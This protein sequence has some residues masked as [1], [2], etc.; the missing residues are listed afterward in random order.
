LA[1]KCVISATF[2]QSLYEPVFQYH[3]CINE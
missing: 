1:A 3:G 2:Y